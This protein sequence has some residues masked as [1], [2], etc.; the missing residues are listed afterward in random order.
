M[1]HTN[2]TAPSLSDRLRS[3]SFPRVTWV[4]VPIAALLLWAEFKQDW[5][6]AQASLIG[7]YTLLAITAMVLWSSDPQFSHKL[8][9]E[10]LI[11]HRAIRKVLFLVGFGYLGVVINAARIDRWQHHLVAKA[12][13]YG[14]VVAGAF[15]VFGVLLGFLFGLRPAS[16]AHAS[17]DSQS[18]ADDHD[19]PY[20]NLEEIADWLTK[21]ILGAGLVE[22]T[23]LKEPILQ[24]ATFMAKGVNPSA[25][26]IAVAHPS[27]QLVNAAVAVGVNSSTQAGNPDPGSPAIALAIMA[28]FFFSGILYGYLWT[29]FER[30]ATIPCDN[31]AFSTVGAPF[32]HQTRDTGAPTQKT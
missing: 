32:A 21:L 24:L 26:M 6:I 5:Y 19:N 22:L 8:R 1:E 14:T 16:I 18:S 2:S 25:Q 29:R 28:F 11:Y 13:G 23:H 10:A 30:A 27:L 12:I 3:V 9:R 20:T 31:P 4:A 7:L 17:A 15:F